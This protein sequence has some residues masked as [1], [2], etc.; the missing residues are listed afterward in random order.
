M[1]YDQVHKIYFNEE[2]LKFSFQH[3]AYIKYIQYIKRQYI[4]HSKIHTKSIKPWYK[5]W[6]ITDN[7]VVLFSN[8]DFLR[9]NI[10]C[11]M[12]LPILPKNRPIF[13]ARL[14][15]TSPIENCILSKGDNS[16]KA[17]PGDRS[18]IKLR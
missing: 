5:D 4:I 11:N 9:K 3:I 18:V 13:V 16:K 10:C 6:I 7:Y 1:I 8:K 12:I 2:S 15:L 14:K 17:R